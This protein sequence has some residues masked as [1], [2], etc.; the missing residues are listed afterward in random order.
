MSALRFLP[1]VPALI[2]AVLLA[3]TY[4][5][6]EQEIATATDTN[7][8]TRM[9]LGFTKGLLEVGDALGAIRVRELCVIA[10][11]KLGPPRGIVPEPLPKFMARAEVA[12]PS[13]QP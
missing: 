13:V 9:A 10:R 7:W 11:L 5:V 8:L 3:R 4:F 12:S 2:L 1:T 6:V